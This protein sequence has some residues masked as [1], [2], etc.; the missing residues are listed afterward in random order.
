VFLGL[1]AAPSSTESA[2]AN[3]DTR[4]ISFSNAHTNESGSFTYMVNGYYDQPTLDKLNWFMRDWRLNEPTKMDPKLFDIIWQV[5]RDSG[6]N[7]PID[8]LSAYRSPQTNAM[9]R[10]RSRQVAEHSQ[11]M[12]GR[13]IDAHFIDVGPAAIRDVAMRMQA[14]GVGFYPIG[15]TPWV[16]IDSGSVRYWPRMSRDALTRLFPDGKTVFIPADGQPMPG[17]DQARAEI[18]ARG[19]AIQTASRGSGFGFLGFLFGGPRG[20]GADDDEEGGADSVVMSGRGGLRASG[21]G[22]VQVAYAGPDVVA[23]ARGNLPRGQT[24]MQPEPA[25]QP[26]PVAAPSPQPAPAAVAALSAP[27]P[28]L[29]SQDAETVRDAGDIKLRGPIA[30]KFIAPLPPKR[31]AELLAKADPPPAPMPPQRPVA[32][33]VAADESKPVAAPSAR[34]GA[35]MIAALLERGALPRAITHGVGSAPSNALSLS[36]AGRAPEPPERPEMLE[37]AA[38]LT[39]PLPPVRPARILLLRGPDADKPIDTSTATRT[40]PKPSPEERSRK[41]GASLPNPYGDLVVDAF[42][43]PALVPTSAPA[44]LAEGLRGSAQ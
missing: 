24:Y 25:P 13:A 36:E 17:Y 9:L 30:A 44:A 20:G 37:R 18:E 32:Y 2:I 6:S 10:R 29:A 5:Y 8:V 35:D 22:K 14:G 38:A 19:G 41:D 11:H 21:G 31:P 28:D 7:Q 23:G 27:S 39:A 1:A 33:A 12:E 15:A 42:N 3:G 43:A 26:A 34:A 16:H 40:L 4:T